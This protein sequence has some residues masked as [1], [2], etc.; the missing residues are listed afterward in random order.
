MKN[1]Y[2]FIIFFSIVAAS[3]CIKQKQPV[4]YVDPFIGTSGNR[5]MLFPGP[6]LP[7][8]MVKLSPD[9]TDDYVM[10]AGYEYKINSIAGFGHVHSW[11]MGSFLTMPA[12]GEIKI[13]P[14]TKDDPDSGY[15]SRINHD[16][17]KA[18]PGYYS[19]L[20]EDYG[21]KAELTATTRG[22]FQRYT[23]PKVENGHI[24]FDL[25]VP[26]EDKPTIIEAS[27]KK[28]SNTEI[29]GYVK[30][31][32]GWNEYILHFVARFN[33][34]FESLG[35]WQGA[36]ILNQTDEVRVTEDSDIGA[37]LNFKLGNDPVVLMKTGIS[38]VSTRQAR[39]NMESEIDK[40]QWDFDA[41][42]KN[43]RDIW[44]NLL[45]KIKVEGGTETD[46]VKFYTNLY[47]SYS[48]RTIYSDV[49]GLYV[50]MCEK[51]RQLPDPDSP[52]YGCDAFWMTFWNLNQLWGLVTPDVNE[53]WVKSL[54]EIYDRG[55]WLSNG[56]AG[57]EY[58]GIMVAEHEIP[59][60]V[61]AWQKG[62]R[63]FDGK[64]AYKAMKEIQMTPARPH[65]CGGFVGNRNLVPYMAMGYVPA[66][67]G[68]VSNTLEYAYNDWC[69]AQMA[70]SLGKT[71]DYKYFMQRAQNYRNVFD[72]STGYI[73]PKYEGGP[74]LEEFSPV[75][76]AVG[77]E[78]NF[79]TRDYVEANA[80]Q[81]TW[82]VP[83]D[84][85]GLIHLMGVDEFNNR[86]E[87]GF[88]K[89]RPVFTSEFVNHSNQPNMQA[90]WLFNYSGKPWL[91]QYW[92]REILD[93]YYGTNPFDGYPGDE[94]EGQMGAWYVMSAMGLFEMDGGA[95]SD[96]VYE[97]SGPIFKKITIQLD[98]D[99]YKGSKFI[100]EAKN[101]SSE[102]RY[103]Q[104]ATFNGKEL[105]KFWIK[106]SELVKGGR[107]ILNMGPEPDKAWASTSEH[108]Q[109]MDIDPIVTTPYIIDTDKIF[110]KDKSVKLACDTERAEIYYTL[111]GSQPDK[112]SRLYKEPFVVNKTTSIRMMAYRGDQKSLPALAEIKKTG[113]SKPVLTGEVEP[114]LSYRYIHGNF[115]MVNDFQTIKPV[116][117]G[118]VP[119]FTI[120]PREKEQFF[121][122]DF[123]G[124]I[125]IPKDGL[126]TIYLTT[127]DG[128][129]L[130]IDDICLIN[131]DGLHPLIEIY[132]PVALKAG[133][134]PIS[135]KYFQEGGTN[136]LIVS[137]QGPGIE[138]QEIPAS[139]LF[140]KKQ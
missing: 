47:H 39:L 36:N 115:R 71:D 131:N 60:I 49:N 117:T 24:L 114:G 113:M 37:L 93:H 78:D 74:W 137:W 126:Y 19:V 35:G 21:I 45:G 13:L 80:W 85:K 72:H 14:G 121:A 89:S 62:I 20:L 15:R 67:D 25:Q 32:A 5:W 86:L 120:E 84:L 16:T 55:G 97:I 8:G 46:K 81:Y 130:Y 63:N 106:H 42:H 87:E 43:A 101:A 3:G 110:L 127:N 104:S 59:L 70:K 40:F 31:V 138:K 82:F 48:A 30:R 90:A 23:F 54:L 50:D 122:F 57:I 102:N 26:E 109:I 111:D 98:P 69:V 95:S 51:V 92:V 9:N 91:T 77:K 88:K 44:N 139:V 41:V 140:H 83:H 108:P 136:G 128:G 129:R 12:T 29:E 56:P 53:K 68:P 123:E 34:P 99:Y 6:C 76:S 96:P 58:S 61:G 73:R 2:R 125:R 79:G 118:V 66:D 27:I 133:L 7:F 17:E 1:I 135:V 33:R 4:D 10:D 18:S 132:K 100:I 119:V 65:E 124:F 134:H 38:Y 103:I 107:L 28:V 22:G 94:D 116:K 112:N 75:K 52:V 105:K 64:K 11:A